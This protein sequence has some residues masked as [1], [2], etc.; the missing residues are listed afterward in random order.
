MKIESQRPPEHGPKADQSN[1]RAIKMLLLS[2]ARRRPQNFRR[3]CIPAT[4]SSGPVRSFVR[5][6]SSC[7]HKTRFIVK[8]EI[9]SESAVRAR[10]IEGSIHIIANSSRVHRSPHTDKFPTSTH[11][12]AASNFALSIRA[13]G[14]RRASKAPRDRSNAR[15]KEAAIDRDNRKSVKTNCSLR[16]KKRLKHTFVSFFVF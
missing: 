13:T 6:F 2:L 4:S 16:K 1:I 10:A 8:G 5:S 14:R 3:D 7:F 15:V 12:N 11:S 9:S